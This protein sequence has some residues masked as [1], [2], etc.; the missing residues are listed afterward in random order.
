MTLRSF[1]GADESVAFGCTGTPVATSPEIT[2]S[3]GAG[4]DR[5]STLSPDVRVYFV[6]RSKPDLMHFSVNSA[7]TRLAPD[8]LIRRVPGPL[9]G[10]STVVVVTGAVV[11]VDV[12]LVVGIEVVAGAVV[13]GAVVS[14][15]VVAGAVD[16]GASADVGV[17]GPDDVGAG[18]VVVAAADTRRHLNE[19][20]ATL[21]QR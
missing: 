7:G 18:G 8:T 2:Q 13:A 20:A 16:D 15:A 4:S 17:A 3:I 14:G 19:R 1:V 11:V 6:V 9:A 5:T 10:I 21:V 12:V